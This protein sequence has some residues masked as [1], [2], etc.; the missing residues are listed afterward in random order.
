MEF[1]NTERKNY[2][3]FVEWVKGGRKEGCKTARYIC[4][5]GRNVRS[6]TKKSFLHW[7]G[8]R[9][10]GCQFESIIHFPHQFSP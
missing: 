1:D 8:I 5:I 9:R 6:F 3:M 2:E 7:N 10:R 4:C